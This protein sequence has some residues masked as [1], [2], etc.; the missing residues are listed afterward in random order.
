MT[1]YANN[2]DKKMVCLRVLD[3]YN[4]EIELDYFDLM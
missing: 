4:N 1:T 2:S 3:E